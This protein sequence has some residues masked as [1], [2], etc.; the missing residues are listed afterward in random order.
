MSYEGRVQCI[1]KSGHYFIYN[2]LNTPKCH[3]G[4]PNVWINAVDDTNGD[5]FGI[6]PDAVLDHFIRSP[7]EVRECSD[8]HLHIIKEAIYN[9]PTEVESLRH[10]WDDQKGMFVPITMLS[11]NNP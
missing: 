2:I 7:K 11:K 1:C 6:I 10:Y 9:I 3:C 4:A 5:Q 8:G